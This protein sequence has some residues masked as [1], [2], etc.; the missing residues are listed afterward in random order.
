M[1]RRGWFWAVV[2]VGVLAVAGG[3]TAG[4]LLGRRDDGKPAELGTI[5]PTSG[6]AP[7][8]LGFRF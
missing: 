2:G 8:G 5:G 3:V 4:V 6:Q 1:Y 7:T